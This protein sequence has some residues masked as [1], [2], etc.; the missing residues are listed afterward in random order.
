M[1]SMGRAS[2]FALSGLAFTATCAWGCS[3][4][5]SK[6]RM[7]G[8]TPV[9]GTSPG[10]NASAGTNP[11]SSGNGSSTAGSGGSSTAGNSGTAGGPP[12]CMVLPVQNATL[13]EFTPPDATTPGAG[14]A[15]AGG[16]GGGAA[17]TPTTPITSIS[18]GYDANPPTVA[19]GYSFFYPEGKL[20]S[21]MSAGAWNLAGTVDDYAG[22]QIAF[23]CG[24]D[25]EM[26]QGIS[27]TISGNVGPSGTLS[28]VVAH[29]ADTWRDP[30]GVEPTVAK[31]ASANQYDGTCTEATAAVAVTETETTVSLM[32]ADIKGGKPEAN[33][34][35]AEIVALR[36]LFKWDPASAADAAAH[37]YDV[38]VTLD[39]V[40][41]I[42]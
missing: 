3:S 32:W 13:T 21:D 20:T 38:D 36:W 17:E 1:T 27:F 37:Q 26:Y 42:E 29:A 6:A 40:K 31:C 2:L 25:A 22:F 24:A 9:S 16:E 41:L 7:E 23:L 14:G 30:N 15:G 35:P 34:N 39:D 11:S 5:D 4:Q 8:T 33:P 19:S 28:F 18:F 12:T 10:G